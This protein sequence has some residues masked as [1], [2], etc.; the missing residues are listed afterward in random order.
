[1]PHFCCLRSLA[2]SWF[3]SQAATILPTRAIR[4]FCWNIRARR[5]RTLRSFNTVPSTRTSCRGSWFTTFV[6]RRDAGALCARARL[7]LDRPYLAQQ[8]LVL[9]SPRLA[10]SD[11][12]GRVVGH[13]GEETAAVGDLAHGAGTCRSLSGFQPHYRSEVEHQVARTVRSE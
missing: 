7:R 1:M 12:V 11:R 10:A 5:S 4:V 2:P 9:Q 13:R 6:S 3:T 8:C